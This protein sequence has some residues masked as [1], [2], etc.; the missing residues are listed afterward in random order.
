M[1]PTPR[2]T[3]LG[4]NYAP[5]PSGNAPYS[6]AL[7]RFLASQGA[8]VTAIT[9]H[10]HYPQWER[11]AGYGGWRT[12]TADAG[13]RL[14]RLAH[15]VPRPPRGMRRL[16]SEL[17]FGARQACTRWY[18]PTVAVMVSP[19]LFATAWCHLR[20]LLY[21]R[22][23]RVV[24]VQDLY[25]QGMAE[26]GEGSG[27]AVRVAR[28]VESWVLRRAH[29]VVAIHPAMAERI[30][31]L[32][33]E[34]ARIEVVPNWGHVTPSTASRDQARRTLGWTMDG[35]VVLHSGNMGRKQGLGNVVEAAR[36]AAAQN[37]PVHFVLLGDGAERD[38]LER[39]GAGIDRL[40]VL[41]PVA[42]QDFP[43][44]LRAANALLVNELP[45]VREMAV[46][47]KLTSYVSAHRPVIAAGEPDGV[48]AQILAATGAGVSVASGNPQAL[49]DAVCALAD[50]P[51]R[52]SRL[53]DA[54]LE[55]WRTH[56]NQVAAL[57]RWHV[58]VTG[59]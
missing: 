35:F 43:V 48:V 39:A 41:D 29:V 52:A 59:K 13:V 19:A 32:G 21:P 55:Y 9:G 25:S 2:V 5:E 4:L 34:R 50:D 44:A 57:A 8:H 7:A 10:P 36:L 40:H 31:E 6:T 17:V 33:V 37:V 23:R 30:A 22:V 49:L 28:A 38:A 54:G 46:P 51:E 53:A 42:E 1:Q 20:L 3:I 11:Y 56:L 58:L 18:R 47:S 45:G 14:V 24:W 26:T 15:P 12:V 27:L 16:L